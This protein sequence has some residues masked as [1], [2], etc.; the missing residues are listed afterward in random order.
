MKSVHERILILLERSKEGKMKQKRTN[1][2]NEKKSKQATFFE[3]TDM[4]LSV[5]TASNFQIVKLVIETFISVVD[6]NI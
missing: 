4:N 2:T 1:K 6:Y 3:W 5:L